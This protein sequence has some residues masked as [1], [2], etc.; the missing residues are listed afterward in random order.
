[1]IKYTKFHNL[2]LR[3]IRVNVYNG[4]VFPLFAENYI[5]FVAL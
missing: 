1:M 4:G 5:P 3:G 2:E